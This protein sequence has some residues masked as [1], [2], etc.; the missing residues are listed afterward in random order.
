MS[1]VECHAE[2]LRSIWLCSAGG[3]ILREYP[4][5]DNSA[6]SHSLWGIPKNPADT[7]EE[8]DRCAQ[9]DDRSVPDALGMAATKRI[10]IHA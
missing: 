3:Q 6:F 8:P 2:V 5:D 4:Q 10:Q 7:S 1:N 9:D